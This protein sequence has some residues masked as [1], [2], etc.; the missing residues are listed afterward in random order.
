MRLTASKPGSINVTAWMNSLQ[1]SAVAAVDKNDLVISGGTT[2][3]FHE[4]YAERHI[5]GEIKWQSRV[6]IQRD[7]GKISKVKLPERTM[8]RG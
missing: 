2:D 7:G 6:Q 5:P 8:N 3:L 1:E 4:K